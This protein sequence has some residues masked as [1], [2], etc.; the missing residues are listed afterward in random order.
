MS[1]IV[2]T[3]ILGVV[4]SAVAPMPAHASDWWAVAETTTND[5]HFID[6]SSIVRDNL[7]ATY[8]DQVIYAS[9]TNGIALSKNRWRTTGT[10]TQRTTS[11][12]AW[13]EFGSDGRVIESGNTA[14]PKASPIVLDSVGESKNKFVC[15]SLVERQKIGDQV[16]DPEE[17]IKATLSQN[18]PPK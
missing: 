9:Q 15:G 7:T 4:L 5:V 13:N 1:K 12:L 16:A 8:W 10:G 18:T 17:Y 3:S 14:M 2:V 11:L 6:A